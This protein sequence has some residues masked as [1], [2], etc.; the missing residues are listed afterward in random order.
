MGQRISIHPKFHTNV[1]TQT[2]DELTLWRKGS[3][4][5][6]KHEIE[7]LKKTVSDCCDLLCCAVLCCPMPG[8]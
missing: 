6:R 3:A 4:E 7:G 2:R 5:Y 8:W 1:V